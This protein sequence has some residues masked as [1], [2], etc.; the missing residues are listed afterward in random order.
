MHIACPSRA[1]SPVLGALSLSLTPL[2]AQWRE[3]P[4]TNAPPL[5]TYASSTEAHDGSVL[6]FGGFTN[7]AA[8][9]DLWSFRGTEWRQL[10]PPVT[11]GR[12]NAAMAF[13]RTR[14][15][16]VLF[17]GTS[18]LGSF[19]LDDTWTFDGATWTR[20]TPTTVPA[21]R[22]GAAM[23]FDA[24]RGRTVMFG[25]RS[26]SQQLDDTWEWDGSDWTRV[27]T[28]VNPPP[29]GT[30]LVD[31]HA[32]VFDTARQRI[33]LVLLAPTGPVFWVY[34]G[35]DWSA[36][37]AQP[38]R[39]PSR[40]ADDPTRGRLVL[41]AGTQTYEYDGAAW[42]PRG[43]GSPLPAVTQSYGA[44]HWL[45]AGGE[46]VFVDAGFSGRVWGRAN[47]TPDTEPFGTPCID[48]LRRLDAAPGSAPQ[49]GR[50]FR[51]AVERDGSGNLLIGTAGLSRTQSGPVTLPVAIP[52]SPGSCLLRVSPDV[53][54]L[55][56]GT[57]PAPWDLAIPL[58]YALLGATLQTQALFFGG[59][60]VLD[61]T[62][63]LEIRVGLPLA[64]STV[65]E[66]FAGE[67]MRD[68]VASGDRW[69]NGAS[70]PIGLGGDG[71]HGSFDPT[72]GT[73]LAANV[74]EFSTDSQLI[75]GR[76]TLSGLDE[77]VTNGEFAF[78]D[79]VLPAGVTVRFRGAAPAVLRVRGLARIEG[80][81]DADAAPMTTFRSRIANSTAVI[82]GQPGGVGGPGGGR[83][84]RGG[85]SSTGSGTTVV[86][87]VV[88]ENGRDGEDVRLP[89]GHAYAAQ[90]AGTGGRGSPLE[91]ATGLNSSLTFTLNFVFNGQVAAGGGGGGHSAAGAASSSVPQTFVTFG[92]P[93]AGGAAFPALPFPAAPPPG[94]SSLQHFLVG[95]S[96]GGGAGTHPF[97]SLSS[98]VGKWLAGGGGSG[99]GGA[100]ALRCGGDLA[101]GTAGVLRARGGA[102]V[103]ID[104]D[105]PA[106]AL[107][108]D[109]VTAPNSWGVYAPGG[110]GSGG[111]F[112]LQSAG[113]IGS[114]GL[115]DTSGGTGS[116][117]NGISPANFNL[118]NR[119]GN[120]SPGL[121]RVEARTGTSLTGS[122]VPPP[123]T[124]ALA[125]A[126]A[127]SGSRSRWFST[128]SFGLPFFLRYELLA[129]VV[130]T[131]TL[132]SDDPAYGQPAD[133]PGA[134]VRVRF[135]TARRRPDGTIDPASLGPWRDYVG[136]WQAGLGIGRDA[137]DAF[138]FD[139]VIDT[140][141]GPVAV[142][143]L[144]VAY[145]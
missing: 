104:G 26:Q 28:T 133:G 38:P 131:A 23:A 78:S 135:Q 126:D 15:E 83:G 7:N 103:R 57:S 96:G 144:R 106:T 46:V 16:V 136:P 60:G 130:G 107:M 29:M 117:T 13:D 27:V 10:P 25:G 47:D 97:A 112:L 44:L 137:G 110:G 42:L 1:V 69:Q 39:A 40:M 4:L 56:P 98:S 125:D 52:G 30:L 58:D 85:D 93:A 92:A 113:A 91:P 143:E 61:A 36:P 118:D 128:G 63:G 21:R 24:R 19:G 114:V 81:L 102:G 6:L 77:T 120:G 74:Y 119:G 87:G 134:P 145:R 70:T 84:G 17:G 33:S 68:P 140:S 95:G 2:L 54:R 139:L 73:Q 99:G 109:P 127:G 79:F 121:V 59:A 12:A 5:R 37:G 50:V 48:P 142:R 80:T 66:T 105:D 124:A 8:R 35:A 71:R 14:G 41:Q 9:T 141:N 108:P 55:L 45:G 75:P 62:N 116:F 82:A 89:A 88:Q 86:G 32:M 129:D 3:I 53:A 18:S 11:A 100:I 94:Y 101:I 22:E 111:S 31:T 138:R 43:S 51:M 67:A 132:F 64:D 90:A 49:L 122:F 72:V 115:V 20:R 65:T 76:L 123:S 34:D